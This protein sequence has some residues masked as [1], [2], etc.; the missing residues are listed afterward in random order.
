M[1][2]MGALAEMLD[3]PQSLAAQLEAALEKAQQKD[4]RRHWYRSL[5]EGGCARFSG[6]PKRWPNQAPNRGH[7]STEPHLLHLL[8]K[9]VGAAAALSVTPFQMRAVRVDCTREDSCLCFG[10]TP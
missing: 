8:P 5:L 2:K 3:P 10:K 9:P 1:Q 7:L 6:E 4:T